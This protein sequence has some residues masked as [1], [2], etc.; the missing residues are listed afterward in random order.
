MLLATCGDYHLLEDRPLD[1]LLAMPPAYKYTWLGAI[2]L[3]HKMAREQRRSEQGQMSMDM[4]HYLRHGMVVH[5]YS[6][7]KRTF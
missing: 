7:S 4:S 3:A 6:R 2:S 5:Y 1:A